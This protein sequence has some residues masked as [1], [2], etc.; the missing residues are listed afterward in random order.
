VPA[1]RPAR[2]TQPN[3]TNRSNPHYDETLEV[4]VVAIIGDY[5]FQFMIE[6]LDVGAQFIL[7]Y[8]QGV[9]CSTHA[10]CSPATAQPTDILLARPLTFS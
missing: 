1:L 4:T 9:T 3:I 10:R 5:N 2:P 8:I 6:E 7:K